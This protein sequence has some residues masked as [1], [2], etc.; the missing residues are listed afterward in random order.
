MAI[1]WTPVEEAEKEN[2]VSGYKLAL[3]ES[4][5]ILEER[6]GDER[7]P[8]RTFAERVGAAQL[9]FTRPA[10]VTKA[11]AYVEGLR[12]GVTGGLTKERAKVYLQS[13]RQAV[14][15]L[16]DLAQS[17]DSFPAQVKLYLGLLKGKQRWLLRG[18]VGLGIFFFGVLILADTTPGQLL[19]T[20]IVALVHLFFGL[21]VAILIALGVMVAV[22]LGTAV[23]LGRQRGGRV[24]GEDEE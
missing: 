10:D 20:G 9:H 13:L 11:M 23:Y 5:K 2:T 17:R 14:A 22:I 1:D 4:A 21:I 24:R 3:L 6:L 15:D 7:V 19:V 8:G 18:L 16:N 12:H